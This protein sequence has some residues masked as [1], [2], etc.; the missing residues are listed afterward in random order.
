[1]KLLT[2]KIFAL[3]AISLSCVELRSENSIYQ[4]F[5]I[6][7][8]RLGE[9]RIG[10]PIDN[11]ENYLQ[12]FR[13]ELDEAWLFGY[14]GGGSIYLYYDNE[15]PILGLIPKRGTDT[16]KAIIVISEKFKNDKG[17]STSLTFEDLKQLYPETEINL[18]EKYGWE[19]SVYKDEYF[20]VV[21]MTNEDNRIGQYTFDKYGIPTKKEELNNIKKPIDWI[22]IE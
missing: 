19:W 22:A 13:R 4:D 17:L 16:V 9:I 11:A 1:M 18:N 12:E 20:H 10:Q 2:L 6:S 15:K 14:G 3:L 21:F 5:K 8:G 7:K